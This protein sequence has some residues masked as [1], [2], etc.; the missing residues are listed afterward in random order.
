MKGREDVSLPILGG[1]IY[2]SL[3][4]E[5]HF[6]GDFEG[7]SSAEDEERSRDFLAH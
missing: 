6:Q 3:T 7:L 4:P 5:Q 2:P 1:K